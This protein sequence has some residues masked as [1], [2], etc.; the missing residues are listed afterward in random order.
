MVTMHPGIANVLKEHAAWLANLRWLGRWEPAAL[1]LACAGTMLAAISGG[2]YLGLPA[3]GQLLGGHLLALAAILLAV[4]R[5]FSPA[6]LVLCGLSGVHVWLWL[7][8]RLP[9]GSV[10]AADYLIAGG[11]LAAVAGFIALRN[12]RRWQALAQAQHHDDFRW[13]LTRAPLLLRWRIA[14]WLADYADQAELAS[15][16]RTAAG[17]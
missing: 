3:G 10:I 13:L 6:L 12:Q 17:M 9:H 8:Q 1:I 15:S 14:R 16:N 2:V 5:P 11:G 4:A 7:M